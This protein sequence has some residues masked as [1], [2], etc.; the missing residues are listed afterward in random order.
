MKNCVKLLNGRMTNESSS[1]PTFQNISTIDYFLC[2]L[3]L[4]KYIN[5]FIVREP[6]PLFSDGHSALELVLYILLITGMG[7]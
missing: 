6:N 3:M 4:F 1:N 2:C 7:T 5:N